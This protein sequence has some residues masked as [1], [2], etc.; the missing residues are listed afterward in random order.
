M[1][2]TADERRGAKFVTPLLVA[3]IEFRAW[4]ADKRLRHASFRGYETIR[5]PR[6]SYGRSKPCHPVFPVKAP[7]RST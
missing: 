3:E 7:R 1:P 4:T 2:L 5:L 6:T